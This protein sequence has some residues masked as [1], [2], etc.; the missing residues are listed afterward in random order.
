[1]ETTDK[2]SRRAKSTSGCKSVLRILISYL[3]SLKF[4][5]YSANKDMCSY[6]NELGMDTIIKVT[7]RHSIS[8]ESSAFHF[9][10]QAPIAHGTFGG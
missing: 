2:S 3:P 1:M 10:L 5:R 7:N 9:R 4:R 6:T 8:S